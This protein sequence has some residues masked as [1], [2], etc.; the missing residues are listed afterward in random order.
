MTTVASKLRLGTAVFAVA[1]VAVIPPVLAQADET[2]SGNSTAGSS[3]ASV[4]SSAGRTP[5][6]ESRGANARKAAEDA[7]NNA[8]T[9][10]DNNDSPASTPGAGD[11]DVSTDIP[12]AALDVPTADASA[13]DATADATPFDGNP[14]FQNPLWWFGSPNPNPP[15]QVVTFEFEP[16]AD[17]PGWS[18]PMYGWLEGFDFEACVG[19]VGTVTQG[20]TVVG[21]YGTSTSGVS[22]G[23]A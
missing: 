3:D 20:Q 9:G 1:A 21:P 13:A 2:D 22:L 6:R 10:S 8:A 19:G 5:K 7:R 17:L 4:G 23:C 16:L 12:D 15:E 18:Q 11:P 14:L